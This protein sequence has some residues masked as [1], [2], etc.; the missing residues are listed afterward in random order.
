MTSSLWLTSVINVDDEEVL[1]EDIDDSNMNNE[2]LESDLDI[3]NEDIKSENGQYIDEEET[4]VENNAVEE[5]Q[6]SLRTPAER[7]PKRFSRI[8]F[9]MKDNV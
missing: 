6:A 3:D 2:D 1:E 4:S 5:T 9:K 8:K 7:R